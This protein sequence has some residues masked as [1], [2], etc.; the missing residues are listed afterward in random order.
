MGHVVRTW[1]DRWTAL[2]YVTGLTARLDVYRE[3]CERFCSDN[4]LNIGN[5]LSEN[6]AANYQMVASSVRISFAWGSSSSFFDPGHV[7]VTSHVRD[8]P[9]VRM[10]MNLSRIMYTYFSILPHTY[11]TVLLPKYDYF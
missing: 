7:S 1:V 4:Q 2:F 11:R 6:N 8:H 9:A 5:S 10:Q 3:G